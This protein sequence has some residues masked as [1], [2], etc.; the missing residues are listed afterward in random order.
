MNNTVDEKEIEQFSSLS[1]KWWDKSGP[2]LALHKMSNARI[3]FIRQ[4]ASRILNNNKAE[5]NP[6]MGINCIDIGCG[7]GILSERLK[8]LG[9][10]V[11]GI[12][13]SRSSID[14][15]KEHSIKS[16][17]EINYRCI[18]TSELIETEK[19]KVI[20]K[21]DLVIAS[22]VIEHVKNRKSFLSDISNLC[23]PGGLVIFTTI[24]NSLLGILFAKFFAENVL[25]IVPA[26]THNIQK[27]ISPKTLSEEAQ[28]HNIILDNFIGFTPT[29]K[30]EDIIDR[31]FGE[32]RLTSNLEV[33]YGAAGIKI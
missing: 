2:F 30:F 9:A 3:K 13:A 11:T 8:R 1:N 31:Q 19:E 12:D 27:F 18:S 15:A 10:I 21:F 29:F 28:E 7:G 23:R 14:I 32:F 4:N 17:L 22:E 25:K 26:G 20:N 24:N 5:I 6:F 33:N 16:R